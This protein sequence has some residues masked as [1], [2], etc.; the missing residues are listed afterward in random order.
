MSAAN[1]Q[2]AVN[3]QVLTITVDLYIL[4]YLKLQTIKG[5]AI[6]VPR[7]NNVRIVAGTN[8]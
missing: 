2:S 8:A 7:G 5:T 3:K 6:A 1:I 4:L